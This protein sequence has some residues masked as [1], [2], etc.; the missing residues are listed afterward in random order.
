MKESAAER[1]QTTRYRE[2]VCRYGMVDQLY[3]TNEKQR[4]DSQALAISQGFEC[5]MF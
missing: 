3:V 1:R 4:L 2:P 5:L